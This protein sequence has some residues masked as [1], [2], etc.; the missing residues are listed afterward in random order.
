SGLINKVNGGL[1]DIPIEVC[2]TRYP[3]RIKEYSLRP[4]SGG[5]GEWRGGCGINKTYE[6]LSDQCA[7]GFWWERS[8]TPA[9]GLF[10]GKNG[11]PPSV[12]VQSSVSGEIKCLKANGIKLRSGDLIICQSGG[13][14]GYGD[15]SLRDRKAI[16]DD[17]ADGFITI[18]GAMQDYGYKACP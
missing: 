10:G 4:D 8:V 9:W 13:G 14:G 7:A 1:K 2:E 18:D 11:Q 3:L 17:I 5:A 12:T 15:P 16:D 6:M